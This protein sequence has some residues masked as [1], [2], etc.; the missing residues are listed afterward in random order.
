[1]TDQPVLKWGGPFQAYCSRGP[2]L[3]WIRPGGAISAHLVT[4]VREERTTGDS[5]DNPPKVSS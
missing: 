3:L 2:L 5:D 1:M 4:K